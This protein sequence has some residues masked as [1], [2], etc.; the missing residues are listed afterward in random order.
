MNSIHYLAVRDGKIELVHLVL[1]GVDDKPA[2]QP[3][4]GQQP[5]A[6][7]GQQQPALPPPGPPPPAGIYKIPV[8]SFS[9][10]PIPRRPA[11]RRS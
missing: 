7:T 1:P 11:G 4:A 5:A 9:T 8:D 2:A 10:R 6:S 3:A